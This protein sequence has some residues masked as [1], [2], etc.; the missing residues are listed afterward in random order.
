MEIGLAKSLVSRKRVVLE[1]AKKFFIPED[2]SPVSLK[3]VAI[4]TRNVS[5]LVELAFKYALS[6]SQVLT[7]VGYG[8]RVKGNLG[9]D[10][11]K[12][13]GRVSTILLSVT[14]KAGLS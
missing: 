13:S 2:A 7:L 9:L 11:V 4:A 3:E 12:M 10:F 6:P 14:K 8:Y 1:F 5:A